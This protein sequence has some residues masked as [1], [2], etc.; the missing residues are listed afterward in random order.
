MHSC[1]NVVYMCYFCH[2]FWCSTHIIFFL[3]NQLNSNLWRL[4]LANAYLQS[5]PVF[6]LR[7]FPFQLRVLG[8]SHYSSTRPALMLVKYF[9]IGQNL[10]FSFTQIHKHL[11]TVLYSYMYVPFS[12]FSVLFVCKC[13]LCY[14][15]LVSTQLQLLIILILL[16]PLIIIIIII[17]II[18]TIHIKG[19]YKLYVSTVLYVN[20]QS[21]RI[22]SAHRHNNISVS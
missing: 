7:F 5:F 15:H 14:C 18:S 13:V 6:R 12:V 3:L 10:P 17:I 16:L 21:R 8:S 1:Y 9:E 11:R 2:V 20:T 19:N 22:H 4:I